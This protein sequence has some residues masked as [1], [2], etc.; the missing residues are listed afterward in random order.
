MK[1]KLGQNVA[2]ILLAAMAFAC[3]SRTRH[4]ATA[5]APAPA[6][7]ATT[8]QLVEKIN[9]Q[10]TA[11]QT[12]S[13]SVDLEP[14]TGS[15][16]SGVIKQY[17]DVRGFILAKRPAFIRMVGQAPVV[18]TD[19]F[20][21]A[22]DGA[23]FSVYIP[24]KN[25]FYTGAAS[26]PESSKNPL[27]NLRPQHVVEALLLQPIAPGEIY[28][29]EQ[30]QLAGQTDY[31]ITVLAGS[32]S[33]PAELKRRVW[34]NGANL[35]I[36]RIQLYGAD[37]EFIEG[38]RYANY[39]DFNGTSYPAEI[40]IHRPVEHY[41]LVVQILSAKFNQPAPA[42]KFILKKPADAQLVQLGS[43]APA[44]ATQ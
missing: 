25:R 36:S 38:V 15:A 5:P 31:V 26:L 20:D 40:T 33:G 3:V 28:F 23:Q 34:F 10:S 16:Y 11:V 17:H 30:E 8:A 27:E 42:S 37:G 18:R 14:S 22:S 21:M 32:A 13:A 44:R 6:V 7:P 41:S 24:S 12:L 2:A 43:S 4:V 19:I 35:E 1:R 29:R 39:Q 9:S